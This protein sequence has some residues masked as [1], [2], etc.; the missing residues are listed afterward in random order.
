M[1]HPYHNEQW[2]LLGLVKI[3]CSAKSTPLSS[4]NLGLL[5]WLQDT[6]KAVIVMVHSHTRNRVNQLESALNLILT[7]TLQTLVLARSNRPLTG[8]AEFLGNC[9]KSWWK[10]LTFIPKKAQ[11]ENHRSRLMKQLL[12]WMR[13]WSWSMW[14]IAQGS[15][16]S[17]SPWQKKPLMAQRVLYQTSVWSH[18]NSWHNHFAR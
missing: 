1:A 11:L 5:L 9:Y 3:F 18:W 2:M 17:Y 10:L 12:W 13:C 6:V 7:F 16:E 15:L 14:S 8:I 4:F